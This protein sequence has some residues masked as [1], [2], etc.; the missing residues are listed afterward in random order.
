M[1]ALRTS[2]L[3][4]SHRLDVLVLG[5][6]ELDEL[7]ALCLGKGVISTC[8][9]I[10]V[11]LPSKD[12][13][14][15]YELMELEENSFCREA[16]FLQVIMCRLRYSVKTCRTT[17]K[18]KGELAANELAIDKDS[19]HRP[20]ACHGIIMQTHTFTHTSNTYVWQYVQTQKCS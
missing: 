8:E 19:G 11:I 15:N 10:H 14:I 2:G 4:L 1:A 20:S 18:R 6:V 17:S 3:V 5:I 12:K 9:V 16:V 13:R 7:A